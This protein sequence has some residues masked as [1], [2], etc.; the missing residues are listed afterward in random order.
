VYEFNGFR[1]PTP[2]QNRPLIVSISDGKQK[3]DDFVYLLEQKV[4][5][6]VGV[7]SF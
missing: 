7:L 4:D 1:K 2:L 3:V 6:A 5:D